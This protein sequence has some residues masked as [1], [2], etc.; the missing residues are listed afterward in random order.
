[1]G[2]INSSYFVFPNEPWKG[3]WLADQLSKI[4]P[5]DRKQFLIDT[6]QQEMQ[7]S[8]SRQENPETASVQTE[9]LSVSQGSNDQGQDANCLS[10]EESVVLTLPSSQNFSAGISINEPKLKDD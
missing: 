10:Q 8:Q 7:L 9:S 5:D 1:M 4:E 2:T 3:I 6:L